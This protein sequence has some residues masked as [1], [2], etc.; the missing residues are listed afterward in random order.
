MPPPKYTWEMRIIAVW[1]T[2]GRDCLNACNKNWLKKLAKEISEAVGIN[3]IYNDPYPSTLSTEMTPGPNKVRELPSN[4]L[5]Q[6]PQGSQD[7]TSSLGPPQSSDKATQRSFSPNLILRVQDWRDWTFTDGSLKKYEE[8]QDT[9]SGAYRPCL[10][11]PHYMNPRGVG[12]T[13]TISHAE[14]AAAAAAASIYGYSHI[15]TDSLTSVRQIK[16][17]LSH[18]NLHR[19]HI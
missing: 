3:C 13:N 4:C 1:N 5:R 7:K 11:A 19:H 12:I 2:K 9:G 17:L 14:L 8:R 18:P 10:N 15:A 16:K 6:T